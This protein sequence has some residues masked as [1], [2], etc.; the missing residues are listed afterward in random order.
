M[1]ARCNTDEKFFENESGVFFKSGYPSQWYITSFVLDGITYNCCEQRMMHTKALYF[2]DIETAELIMLATE[3]KE[4]K[5]LGRLVKDFNEDKWNDVA[6]QIVYE[7]NVAKFSQND[8]LK[9]LL[10]ATNNKQFVECSPYDKIWGNGLDITTTLSTPQSMWHGTNRLGKAI[11]RA[12]DTLR[13][14]V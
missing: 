9:A 8:E 6:D 5:K 13:S 3:P 11:V 2:K 14:I 4:Q 12:R 10:L 7:A 1:S